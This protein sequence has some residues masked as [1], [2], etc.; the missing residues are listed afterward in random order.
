MLFLVQIGVQAFSMF[1]LSLKVCCY[2]SLVWLQELLI[3]INYIFSQWKSRQGGLR[4]ESNGTLG[5]VAK[6]SSKRVGWFRRMSVQ[7]SCDLYWIVQRSVHRRRTVEIFIYVFIPRA[8]PEQTRSILQ[9]DRPRKIVYIP[10]IIK[11]GR[12]CVRVLTQRN[13]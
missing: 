8:S 1:P 2:V 4:T 9:T 13:V 10:A 11:Y 7:S 12:Y 3:I 5:L 6:A